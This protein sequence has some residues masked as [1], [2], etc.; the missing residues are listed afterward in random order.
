M[1]PGWAALG[2]QPNPSRVES[3]LTEKNGEKKE[4]YPGTATGDVN[5][6]GQTEDAENG[7]DQGHGHSDE[8][9]G[10]GYGHCRLVRT[11]PIPRHGLL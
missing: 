7:D 4:R 3:V 2:S 9:E 10:H 1:P 11:L 6:S 8:D 5:H